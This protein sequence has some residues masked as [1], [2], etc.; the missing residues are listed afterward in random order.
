MSTVYI[1]CRH[2]ERWHRS[3]GDF[4]GGTASCSCCTV[5]FGHF[6][7]HNG[8]C[9]FCKRGDEMGALTNILDETINNIH[10]ATPSQLREIIRT[11]LDKAYKVGTEQYVPR[12]ERRKGDRRRG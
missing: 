9:Y 4:A 11:A 5:I 2:G 1:K 3:L 10:L 7:V 8:R 6:G 12:P